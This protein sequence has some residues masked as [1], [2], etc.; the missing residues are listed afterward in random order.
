MGSSS[1]TWVVSHLHYQLSLPDFFRLLEYILRGLW[2]LFLPLLNEASQKRHGSSEFAD[3]L[4]NGMFRGRHLIHALG[5]MRR[6]YRTAFV[7]NV[8]GGLLHNAHDLTSREP[9]HDKL[10]KPKVSTNIS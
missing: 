10:Q 8:L 6:P 5:K 9:F 4:R 2:V 7:E 1:S 3:H